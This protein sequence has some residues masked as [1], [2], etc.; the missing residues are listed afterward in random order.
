MT[1][2]FR[3]YDQCVAL[4]A[5][6]ADWLLP[7]LARL[8]FAGV[9]L[10]YFWASAATKLDGP[11][12][13]TI[14]AYGQIFPRAFDAVGFDPDKLGLWHW[15][16]ALAGA[17][18]EFLLPALIVLGLFT[19]LAALGMIGFVLVQSLTDIFGHG[20]DSGAWFDRASDAL[21]LDQRAFWLFL[22]ALLVVKGPGPLS[23]DR[24]LA[25]VT[26]RLPA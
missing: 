17:W 20:V 5:R 26:V 24:F 15:L 12:S 22:L 1:Q 25:V 6:Q 9:L 16:V 18:A 19:R 21:I 13:P 3:I 11:F 23:A 10:A 8:I 2:L 14:G 7:G 4:M